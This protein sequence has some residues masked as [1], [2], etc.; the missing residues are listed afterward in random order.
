MKPAAWI[1]LLFVLSGGISALLGN[2]L[3]RKIGKKKLS[4]FSL[5]PKHTSTFMTVVLSMALSAGLFSLFLLLSPHD[6]QVL[7]NPD[8]LVISQM[9]VQEEKLAQINQTFKHWQKRTNTG[10]SS[11]KATAPAAESQEIPT[12][13]TQETPAATQSAE[14]PPVQVVFSNHPVQR[15]RAGSAHDELSEDNWDSDFKEADFQALPLSPQGFQQAAEQRAI[16]FQKRPS[17]G[18][19]ERPQA[20]QTQPSQRQQWVLAHAHETLLRFETA[21]SQS[22]RQAEA[23]VAKILELTEAY[24]QQMGLPQSEGSRV[25][26][27]LAEVQALKLNLLSGQDLEIEVETAQNIHATQPLMVHLRSTPQA[28][29][30]TDWDPSELLEEE[31]LQP[32]NVKQTLQQE[33]LPAIRSALALKTPFYAESTA[34][35]IR[36]SAEQPFVSAARLGLSAQQSVKIM[37]TLLDAESLKIRLWMLP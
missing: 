18:R 15:R 27:L 22:A 29:V 12:A 36:P 11:T 4:L 37:N 14:T 16:P 20:A 8:E 26:V 10:L 32:E 25:Q 5:R 30:S 23:T 28:A 24:A 31:R 2:E 21:P 9:E 3:G 33:V 6:R 17:T 35:T 19:S 1:L 7:L 34:Q 13:E